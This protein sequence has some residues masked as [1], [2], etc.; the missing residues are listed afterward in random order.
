MGMKKY[1][2][3]TPGRRFMVTPSYEEVTK[4]TP[5]RSLVRVL[6]K[7]SGRNNTGRITMRHRGGGAKIKYRI[8]D[9]KRTR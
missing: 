1:K 7:H 2:P 5:E 8:V 3:I 6:K 4:T 9:F